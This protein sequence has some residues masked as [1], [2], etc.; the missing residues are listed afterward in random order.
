MLSDNQDIPLLEEAE[1]LDNPFD[2]DPEELLIDPFDLLLY[3]MLLLEFELTDS[4]FPI[5]RVLNF[6]LIIIFVYFG[7]LFSRHQI[8]CDQGKII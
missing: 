3:P 5:Q 1:E 7:G 8:F 4:M 2:T 6:N